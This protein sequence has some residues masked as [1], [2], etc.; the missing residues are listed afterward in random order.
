MSTPF[1]DPSATS[2]RD[3]AFWVYVRQSLYNS[4]ISQEPLDINFSLQLLPIPDLLLDRHPLAWLCNE[5]AWANELLWNTACAA[6]FCFSGPNR[7]D[8]AITRA[9]TWQE[10]WDKNQSWQKSRPKAFDAIGRGPS[11]DEH[12]F[13]EIWFTADWHGEFS[14]PTLC[15]LD[16]AC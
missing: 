13:E 15:R 4:T 16:M 7:T 6:N 5:T 12:V 1:I 8:D 2:L 3:A 10:L 9:T 14:S 11:Q